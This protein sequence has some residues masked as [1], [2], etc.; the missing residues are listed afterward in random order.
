MIQIPQERI[1]VRDRLL[2]MLLRDS[3]EYD[4]SRHPDAHKFKNVNTSSLTNDSKSFPQLH[5]HDR[6]TIHAHDHAT[7][8]L[9]CSTQLACMQQACCMTAQRSA[10]MQPNCR[11][12]AE[13]HACSRTAAWPRERSATIHLQTS[14]T[15]QCVRRQRVLD[16]KRATK[17]IPKTGSS[18]SSQWLK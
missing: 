1:R 2:Y 14:S 12:A 13:S 9:Q 10:C 7:I 11:H 3:Y 4:S 18:E 5:A 15:M 17:T 16:L 6:A 8:P